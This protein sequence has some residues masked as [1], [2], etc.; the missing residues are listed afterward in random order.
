MP[1]L[2]L[3]SPASSPQDYR[4]QQNC[5]GNRTYYDI[6]TTGTCGSGRSQPVRVQKKKKLI[7]L[8]KLLTE[9]CKISFLNWDSLPDPEEAKYPWGPWGPAASSCEI[10]LFWKCPNVQTWYSICKFPSLHISSAYWS[11]LLMH[12]ILHNLLICLF[13][14]YWTLLFKLQLPWSFKAAFRGPFIGFSPVNMILQII[15][16]HYGVMWWDRFQFSRPISTWCV[17]LLGSTSGIRIST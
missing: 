17:F 2:L 13:F 16:W 6:G 4:C 11:G 7:V 5:T 8:N 15:K 9:G 10:F 14:Y 3:K 1:E 12:F